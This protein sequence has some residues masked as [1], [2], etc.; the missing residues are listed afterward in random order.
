M[1]QVADLDL[2]IKDITLNNE[3]KSIYK[4]FLFEVSD[5]NSYFRFIYLP[6]E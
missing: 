3:I 1:E 2:N 5:G 6:Y 4:I